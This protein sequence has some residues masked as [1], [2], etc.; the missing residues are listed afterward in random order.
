[1]CRAAVHLPAEA[2]D[3]MLD[4]GRGP[5][6]VLQAWFQDIEALEAALAPQGPLQ[7]LPAQQAI[8][9]LRAR[10]ITQ[11]AMLVRRVPVPRPAA[12]VAP[13]STYLV[14]YEGPAQDLNAWLSD[15]LRGHA[16]LMAQLPGVRSVE[17][18]TRV[19]WCGFLPW[20]RAEYMQRNQVVFD[21][22]Q[23]LDAALQS[24]LRARM[25]EHY[26]Q[27]PPFSGAVTHFPMCSFPV[28]S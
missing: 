27:L 17:V 15:Y 14:A 2:R 5:A 9:G 12:S 18:Y 25:R 6:L 3:P 10:R 28:E 7:R 23:A 1:L 20:P 11:Q 21:S 26:E 13:C 24:P 8:A 4:D 22:P 19:D 16:P